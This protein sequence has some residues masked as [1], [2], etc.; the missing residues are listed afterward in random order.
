MLFGEFELD[1]VLWPE[2]TKRMD[3]RPLVPFPHVSLSL[4]Y[5]F[6]FVMCVVS[7]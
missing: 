3:G 6:M 1:G 7:S 2:D 4:L 5:I